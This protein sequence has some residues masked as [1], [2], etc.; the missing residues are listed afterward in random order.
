MKNLPKD[1]ILLSISRWSPKGIDVYD[2]PELA[3]SKKLLDDY[4]HGRCSEARYIRE[5]TNQLS[6]YTPEKWLSKII[7]YLLDCGIGTVEVNKLCFLCYERYKDEDGNIPFCH[8]HIFANYM[9]ATDAYDIH[10]YGHQLSCRLVIS[11]T[12]D[13]DTIRSNEE[14]C[15]RCMK[16]GIIKLLK[17]YP[18]LSKFDIEIVQGG[19]KGADMYARR[20]ARKYNFKQTQFDADWETYGKGAGHLRNVEMAEYAV[21]AD[22]TMLIA[23][24]MKDGESK[25]THNM[26]E[27]ARKHN[28]DHI[29]ILYVDTVP[30]K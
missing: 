1:L 22:I 27:N 18:N 11:G 9:N 23:F 21:S 5:Y 13:A 26:I 20:F 7:N 28:F 24:P 2:F 16:Y 4:K 12:R 14:L 17:K 8:R 6:K 30:F 10:E 3:P 25:G 19:A 15:F 29:I